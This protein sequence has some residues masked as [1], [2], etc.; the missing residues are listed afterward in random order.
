MGHS[1]R[2][3]ELIAGKK[4]GAQIENLNIFSYFLYTKKARKSKN[5]I[6]FSFNGQQD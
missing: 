6:Q 4:S 2:I 5:S 1:L 3:K